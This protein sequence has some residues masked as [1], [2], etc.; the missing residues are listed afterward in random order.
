M[1]LVVKVRKNIQS[2]YQEKKKTRCEK[3]IVGLFLVEEDKKQYVLIKDF[4]TFIYNYT[5]HHGRKYFCR[6]CLQAFRTAK[7]LKC[8]VNEC[9]N[10]LKLVANKWF[11]KRM[12]KKRG[13]KKVN[14]LDLKIMKGKKNHHY[15]VMQIL[16]VFQCQ[17]KMESKI[18]MSFTRTNIKKILLAVMAIN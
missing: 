10:L 18:R 8:H 15:F 16:K 1:I 5:L 7:I 17:K 3:N 11:P 2:I 14:M 13:L 12:L 9:F 6:Y 4:K